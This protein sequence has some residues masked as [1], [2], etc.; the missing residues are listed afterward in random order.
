MM[1][2]VADGADKQRR[3]EWNR[4]VCKREE[5]GKVK[6]KV[7]VNMLVK[8]C[9]PSIQAAHDHNHHEMLVAVFL[10]PNIRIS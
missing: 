5:E 10:L 7:E 8:P 2:D 3:L 9:A 4:T 1:E 6:P